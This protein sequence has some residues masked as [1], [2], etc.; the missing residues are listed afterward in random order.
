MR[1]FCLGLIV[2]LFAVPPAVA[3]SEIDF[4]RDIRP[5]L[6]DKCF[7]CHGPAD[8]Q[9]EGGF[10]LDVKE[11][12]LGEADSGESP[13]VPG[14]AEASGVYQ[15]IITD[16]EFL[17]MPPEESHKPLTP[18]EIDL[19][20]R[21]IES[22]APWSEHWA[23]LALRHSELPPVSNESWCRNPIDRFILAR[24]D[25]EGLQP[26][27]E[28]DNAT[29]IRRVTFDLTGL[30]PSPEEVDAFLADE[31]PGA[32]ERVVDRLLQSEHYGEHRA[33][34]WLDA[35]RY[36]DTHGLHLDNYREM[37][38]Y[39]DWVVRAFNDNLPFDQ[40]T[41]H[42]LAGDLLPDIDLDQ[43]IATGFNRCHVTTNEGGSITEEVYVRNV[44][45]R[46]VTTG[47]VFMGVT[48]DCSRC[49]DHKYDP[50]TMKDFYSMFAFFNSLDGSPMD[51]NKEEHPPV[52]KVPTEEQ[53]AEQEELTQRVSDVKER[54]ADARSKVEYDEAS[55]ADLSEAPE[56]KEYVWIEDD[57]PA[58]AKSTSEGQADGKWDFVTAPKPVYSGENSSAR[59]SEGRSQH[60]FEGAPQVLRVGKEDK[61]FAHVYLDPENPP[62]EI[63]MQWHT[64]SWSHR[65]YWG[66]NLIDWGKDGSPERRPM[67]ELP[68]VGKWVRLEV[69]A[70]HVGIKPG[71]KI[72]GWAFTQFDG[73]VY[74][75]QAGMVTQTPQ[76][77]E[78]YR[79]LTEWVRAQRA[80]DSAGLPE[81]IKKIVP[82]D[83]DQRDEKQ[84][85]QLLDYFI[86]H[87][88]SETRETF[89]TLHQQLAD[90]ESALTDVEKAI[91]TTL[92]FREKAE[93]KPAYI[94]HRGEYDQQRDQVERAV[95][96]I[97]PPLPDGAPQDRLGFAQWLV[98]PAHPLT[99]RVA[100]NRLWQ[101]VFGT[102]MVKTTEDFGSQ[103]EPPS[104]PALLDW[105]AVEFR[106]GGWDVKAT[107]KRLVMSATYRQ[108]STLTA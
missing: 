74:W 62:K 89:E 14:D 48:L 34:F 32:Y 21:W 49:H 44:V 35:A 97:L 76:S 27:E 77:D 81:A 65:A 7:A 37:W 54:I 6:S 87:A 43:Q 101:Q 56:R 57:I 31:A 92:V 11:S 98:S 52:I 12:A 91:A 16:D 96:A 104:H 55:D 1:Y 45:D 4:G 64:G 40:F 70:A 71:T 105:L 67:G 47:A 24:L 8:A 25:D 38:P 53:Q 72:Q 61:L 13:V 26:N 83:R 17:V 5:I 63:M 19:I 42:Q 93:P 33:R 73:T 86:E 107:I 30:P 69:D 99:A 75:D 3:A 60:F 90:A 106:E 9:R 66:E 78:P 18:E 79:T 82:V 20:R 2:F 68:E 84:H 94:L 39:R 22:G 88:Y 36:G 15:R 102:G 59:T 10:R 103:G 50:F 100:V 46:V 85:R 108:A 41:I 95:P 58:G 23:Y 51:G 29:L 80:I 28:A